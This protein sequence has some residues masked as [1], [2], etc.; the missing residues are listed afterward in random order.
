MKCTL[1]KALSK[2]LSLFMLYLY[3]PLCV[4]EENRQWEQSFPTVST[5][6]KE[7]PD[8]KSL[9]RRLGLTFKVNT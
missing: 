6:A 1:F 8:A 4:S 9:S 3:L 7:L 5:P 2:V